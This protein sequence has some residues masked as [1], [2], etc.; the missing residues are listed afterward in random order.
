M[1]KYIAAADSGT[2]GAK[3]TIF[4]LR[5]NPVATAYKE[6]GLIFPEPGWVDQDATML[7]DVCF[8]VIKEAV[9]A[10]NVDPKDIASVCL[11]TQRCTMVPVEADGT[12]LRDAIS[13]QDNRTDPQCE[14]IKSKIGADAFYDTTGLPVANVW[15]LPKIMWLRDNEPE[16]YAKAHR[17]VNVQAL[18]NKALGAE[19]FYDDYSNVSLHGLLSL[20]ELDWIDDFIE[21]LEIDKG[22]LPT[23]VGSG[24]KVGEVSAAGA[25]ATGLNVGT[26][27]ISGAGDQQCAAVGCN[28]LNEGDCEVTLGTAGVT[29]CS[30]DAPN[31][32]PDRKIPCLVHAASGKYTSEGLQN[33]AGA[34]LKWLR[35][36][37][38]DMQDETEVDYEKLTELAD[39]SEPGANG[40]VFLPYL[41][42][43][44]APLWD[45]NA[46]GTFCGI[47]LGSELKDMSRA[48]MEGI[49]Y[50]TAMILDNFARRGIKIEKVRASGGGAKSAFWG[51]LQADIFGLPVERLKVDDATILGAAIL[52]AA[53]AG[54]YGSVEEAAS[55]MVTVAGE[56]SPDKDN[57]AT[58][59]A[60]IRKFKKVYIGLKQGGVF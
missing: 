52:G 16:L 3:A 5:G 50:E 48:V 35:N 37:L 11:S 24:E 53:G 46:R 17:L 13:W 44:A 34:S 43:A 27:I 31:L 39:S 32:D 22:K 59:Q 9:T 2:T 38:Q 12:P 19:D 6:Y 58:Y 15:T 4:D 26:P 20:T 42:G 23:L 36:I 47:S 57:H 28:V 29:I 21:T 7:R 25:E 10:S 60:H 49:S 41:A 45:G 56:Y 8:A 55:E 14:E 51:Q 18:M 40:I 1:T 54:V 30:L 33:A